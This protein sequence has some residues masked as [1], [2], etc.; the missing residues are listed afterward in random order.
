MLTTGVDIVEIDRVAGVLARYG[1]RFPAPGV[2]A[3]GNRLLPG[4]GAQSGGA[5]RG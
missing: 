3:R 5:L 1:D 4:A 2:H